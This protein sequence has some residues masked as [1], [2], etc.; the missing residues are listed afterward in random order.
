M[1]GKNITNEELLRLLEERLQ[2]TS[3]LQER[4]EVL[5]EKLFKVNE[6]LKSAES[7]KGH[8]ISNIT[9]E[10][11]NPF[12][13]ILLLSKNIQKLAKGDMDKA[14]RMAEMINKEA[15]HLDFQ[16]KNIFAAAAIESGKEQLIPSDVAMK[17][18]VNSIIEYFTEQ[19]SS[20]HIQLTF[21]CSED[22]LLK[23][24]STDS[25]KLEIVVKNLLSNAIKFSHAGGKIEV[26]LKAS[27]ENVE[28]VVRDF[29]KGIPEKDRE[30]IFDRF[31]QVD[32]RINSI[33]TG[34]GLGLAIVKSYCQLLNADISIDFPTDGGMLVFLKLPALSVEDID[35]LDGFMIDSGENF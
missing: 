35:D 9:N 24:F 11:I 15:F 28:I 30:I 17:A 33:N 5:T 18:F 27:S 23:K 2:N 31:R 26:D 32:E 29:G 12:A 10:I 19:I 4:I 20:K 8:F 25:V 13:S 6:K 3:G 1:Q 34:H 14:Q 22:S 7:Y 21:N 16:L